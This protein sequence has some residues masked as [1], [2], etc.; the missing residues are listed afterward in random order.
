MYIHCKNIGISEKEE[1][2]I[3]QKESLK[4]KVFYSLNGSIQYMHAITTNVTI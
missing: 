3:P 4:I 2:S 1:Q